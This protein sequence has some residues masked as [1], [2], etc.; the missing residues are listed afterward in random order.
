MR[1]VG[2]AFH[3]KKAS[4]QSGGVLRTPGQLYKACVQAETR[5]FERLGREARWARTSSFRQLPRVNIVLTASRATV[6]RDQSAYHRVLNHWQCYA[7]I[8]S[9]N[10]TALIVDSLSDRADPVQ[11]MNTSQHTLFLDA[12][13]VVLNMSRSLD[14]FL[15]R[16]QSVLLQM[17][18]SHELSSGLVLLRND[19]RAKCF[20]RYVQ[21]FDMEEAP[22]SAWRLL[23]LSESL[24]GEGVAGAVPLLGAEWA[25]ALGAAVLGLLPD[26][27]D[28]ATSTNLRCL[29]SL[30]MRARRKGHT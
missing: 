25:A 16:G 27:G 5:A 9:Y 3:L 10:C 24:A 29:S 7:R 28:A 18:E 30:F 17:T 22:P 12:N 19:H 6:D 4:A 15:L 20:L 23:R 14:P 11:F 1:E 2:K 13:S 26:R 8:H 21:L